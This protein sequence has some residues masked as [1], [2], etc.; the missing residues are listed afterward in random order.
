MYKGPVEQW[1]QL[2]QPAFEEDYARFIQ[3][4]REIYE[5]LAED[6]PP[7]VSLEELLKR[8]SVETNA[9]KLQELIAEIAKRYEE[10]RRKIQAPRKTDPPQ[11][12]DKKDIA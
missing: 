11:P 12:S 1:S 2:S 5:L 3:L 8:A 9:Q 10:D 4:N 6:K 7:D